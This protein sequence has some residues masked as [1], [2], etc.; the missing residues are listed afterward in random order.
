MKNAFR[1]L[2]CLLIMVSSYSALAQARITISQA[3][4][5]WISN[6]EKDVVSA[7]AAMPEGKY[8]FAPTAGEFTGTRTFAEQIKHLAANN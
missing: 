1:I 6:C 4:D 7:A 5:Y 3:L 2:L 8:S